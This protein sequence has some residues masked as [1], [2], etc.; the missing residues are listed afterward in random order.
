MVMVNKCVVTNCS[1]NYKTG[2]KKVS[3]HFHEN[4]ELKRQKQSLG[5]IL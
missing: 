5:G 2:Q 4:Q 3:F 1:T